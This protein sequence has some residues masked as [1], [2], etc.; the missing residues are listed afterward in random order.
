MRHM[1]AL[2][3]HPPRTK[4]HRG[5]LNQRSRGY[6]SFPPPG[7]RNRGRFGRLRA[8]FGHVWED[9]GR[10]PN[11]VDPG[12]SFV[13]VAGPN[14][15]EFCPMFGCLQAKFG[16]F[17]ANNWPKFGRHR[18]QFG[19]P[20]ARSGRTWSN[21]VQSRSESVQVWPAPEQIG[22]CQLSLSRSC[23][24]LTPKKSVEIGQFR[25][26]FEHWTGIRPTISTRCGL[27]LLPR[28]LRAHW[29]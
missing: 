7:G 2:H 21:L 19:H 14:L 18:D 28:H 8:K 29:L 17:R 27:T 5:V 15:A 10:K 13:E 6:L 9:V 25:P 26:Y 4:L 11:V 23:A 20:L 12:P 22:R 1:P 16:G 24:H 3:L